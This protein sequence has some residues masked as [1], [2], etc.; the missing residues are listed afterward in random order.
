[1]DEKSFSRVLAGRRWTF[2]RVRKAGFLPA[3]NALGGI[4]RQTDAAVLEGSG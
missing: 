3:Q 2:K 1:L 4:V